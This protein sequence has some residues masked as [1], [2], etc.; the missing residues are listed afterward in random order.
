MM[1]DHRRIGLSAAGIACFV[2]LYVTQP[3]VSALA[4]EF[5]LPLA[6]IGESVTATLAAV[7]LVAPFVGALSDRLGRKRLIH[8]AAWCLTLPTLLAGLAPS[9]GSFL[10]FRFA[11]G[12]CIPFIFSISVAYIAEEWPGPDALRLTGTF[13]VASILAGFAGRFGS[14]FITHLLGWR[15]VFIVGSVAIVLCALLIGMLPSERRFS[16][17]SGGV[18]AAL[19]RYRD[20]LRQP[21]LVATFCLGFSVL[22]GIVGAFTFATVHMAEPPFSL[23]SAAL[24]SIF[25][26]YLMGTFT[27]GIAARLAARIGRRASVAVWCAVALTGLGLTLLDSL[28]AIVVGLG[29]VSAGIFPEQTLS[30]NFIATAAPRMRSS[31]VGLYTSAY[32]LGGAFG[33][34]LPAAIWRLAGWPGCVA[35]AMCLQLFILGVALTCWRED[36]AS[37]SS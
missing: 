3:M 31:A 12:L 33:G 28:P 6:R 14:G 15:A 7:A 11:Q 23:S 13:Q 25:T 27:T 29:L 17:A 34:I 8:G 21:R 2:M 26:V 37:A 36:R 35:M 1:L 19:V 10:L 24:G 32:Y 16:P 18:T 22:F 9:Y 5:N 20:L 4:V 30:L